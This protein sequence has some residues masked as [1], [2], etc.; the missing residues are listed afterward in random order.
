M[1][2][3]YGFK[4]RRNV[5]VYIGIDDQNGDIWMEQH[6]FVPTGEPLDLNAQVIRETKWGTYI[7]KSMGFKEGTFNQVLA[8]FVFLKN[9]KPGESL[10]EYITKGVGIRITLHPQSEPD[11]KI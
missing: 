10:P 4:N 1:I 8:R 6:F 3:G 9:S 11:E 2:G 7:R 5:K